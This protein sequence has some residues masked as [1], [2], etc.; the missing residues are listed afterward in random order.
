MQHSTSP[1]AGQ[2]LRDEGT[3]RVIDNSP[4]DYKTAAVAAIDLLIDS[5]QAFTADE[6]YAL[7]PVELSPH[8]PNVVPALLGSRARNGQIVSLGYVKTSRK[9]RHASKN[10]VWRAA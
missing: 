10:Q 8:S 4:A 2:H 3:A 1:I 5:R 9:T 6:V 7:I